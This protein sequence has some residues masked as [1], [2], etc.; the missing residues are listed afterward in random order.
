MTN[1]ELALKVLDAGKE[2]RIK[3]SELADI[4]IKPPMRPTNE[5]YLDRWEEKCFEWK[6]EKGKRESALAQASRDYLSALFDA[7]AEQVAGYLSDHETIYH[8]T[9]KYLPDD[10]L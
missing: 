4:P 1:T 7:M 9:S 10:E 8:K 3:E 5:D 2:V 6:I